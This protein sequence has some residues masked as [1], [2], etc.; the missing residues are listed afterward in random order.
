[1]KKNTNSSSPVFKHNINNSIVELEN[2]FLIF[3]E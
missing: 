3:K 2:P 1:M